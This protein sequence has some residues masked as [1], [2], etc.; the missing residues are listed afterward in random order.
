[1]K[2]NISN[3]Q[4]SDKDIRKYRRENLFKS[5]I[6][7]VEKSTLS[8]PITCRFYLSGATAYCVIWI[9]TNNALYVGKGKAGGYGIHRTSGALQDAIN[10]LGIVLDSSI[11]GRG[12]SAID[13]ALKA[14]H[15]A[16]SRK[17]A[18]LMYAHC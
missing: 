5:Q 16:L 12:D 2:A 7:V 4:T 3:I 1:M 13:S 8:E 17:K 11:D 15:K 18:I 14:L 6:S 9:N 10:S